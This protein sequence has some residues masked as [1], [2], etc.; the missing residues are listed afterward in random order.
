VLCSDIL[1]K[2]V[3][4]RVELQYFVAALRRLDTRPLAHRCLLGF[5][6]VPSVCQAPLVYLPSGLRTCEVA[7]ILSLG[8][9]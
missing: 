2:V 3:V 7:E 4:A 9:L 1:K 5:D 8:L 6:V